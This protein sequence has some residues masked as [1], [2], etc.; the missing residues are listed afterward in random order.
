MKN[1]RNNLW[2]T[3]ILLPAIPSL[4]PVDRGWLYLPLDC[5]RR[6]RQADTGKAWR[7]PRR[8]LARLGIT[9]VFSLAKSVCA[10]GISPPTVCM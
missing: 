9:G 5:L 10:T 2:I 3:G 6:G 8:R 1:D 7:S 4:P